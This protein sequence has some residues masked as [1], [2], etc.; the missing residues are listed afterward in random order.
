[1]KRLISHLCQRID[2]CTIGI[3]FNGVEFI[4]KIEELYKKI[5]LPEQIYFKIKEYEYTRFFR[6]IRKFIM[7]YILNNIKME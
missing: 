6:I 1:M 4:I 5:S 3:S 7:L 2:I